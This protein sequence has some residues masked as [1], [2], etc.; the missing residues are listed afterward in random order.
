MKKPILIEIF[1]W[2]VILTLIFS[3]LIFAYS[4]IFVEPN[5]YNIQFKDIDGITKGSPVRFMGINV[6]Y[7]RKLKPKAKYINVQIIVT[8]KDMKIPNGTAARVEF[9]GLGGSKSIELMPPDGSC[10]VGILTSD[11]I[12]INDV[13]YEAIG[14]VEIIEELEKY[15]KGINKYSVQKILETIKEARDDKIKNIEKELVDIEENV[16]EK[17]ENVK[18]K[19]EEIS[20]KIKK[21]NENVEKINEFIK[22]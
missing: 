11:T 20:T 10:N 14:I 7:V 19:Q 2:V 17:F 4:K 21:V 6:G 15:I 12:R 1:I 16:A 5:V 3:G 9:Y 13:A 18:E 22:K 8:K